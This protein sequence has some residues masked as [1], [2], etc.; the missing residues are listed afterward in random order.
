MLTVQVARA[1][2]TL[3][4]LLA[5]AKLPEVVLTPEISSVPPP[6]F[7]IVT[8]WAALVV[9]TGWLPKFKLKGET[10][11]A[12][13]LRIPLPLRLTLW[14]LLGALSAIERV[15]VRVPDVAGVKVTLIVQCAP[16]ATELPQLFV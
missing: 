9:P 7:A 13:A 6:M 8:D 16:A 15:P 2:S 4:Q 3:P 14:G 10:L 5:C 1:A 12:A 11:T